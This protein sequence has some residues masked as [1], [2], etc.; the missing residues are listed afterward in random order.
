MKLVPLYILVGLAGALAATEDDLER[1]RLAPVLEVLR[2][3]FAGELDV[4][5]CAE[6][7]ADRLGADAVDPLAE[8]LRAGALPGEAADDRDDGFRR[9][10]SCTSVH[11][12]SRPNDP[13]TRSC[14]AAP[15]G[16]GTAAPTAPALR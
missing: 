12:G 3:F 8:P 1:P 11:P 10:T 14:A 4:E 5:L 13:S 9:T 2:G 15:A 7:F 16:T 6:R